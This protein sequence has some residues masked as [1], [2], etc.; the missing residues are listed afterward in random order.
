MIDEHMP[1]RSSI[2]LTHQQQQRNLHHKRLL[3]GHTIVHDHSTSIW[4][5]ILLLVAN[6]TLAVFLD[7]C[8]IQET[9][10]DKAHQ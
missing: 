5:M 3:L 1:L 4:E 2:K 10:K 7:H 9:R 6:D 8:R